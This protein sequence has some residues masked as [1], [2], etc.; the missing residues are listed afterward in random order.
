MDNTLHRYSARG[1]SSGKEEVHEA[2]KDLDKGLYPS[3]FCKI[4]PDIISGDSEYCS[5]IHADTAGTKPSLAYLYWKETGDLSVWQGIAQDALVMNFDDMACVGMVTDFILS[6]TIGRN[7]HCITGDVI[8]HL[9]NGTMDFVNEMARHNIKINHGGGETADVGDIVRT[10]DVGFTIFGRMKRSDLVVNQIRP[11]QL[12]VGVAGYGQSTYESTYNS[13][14]GSNGLTSARHDVLSKHYA[15]HYPES[16]DPK[17]PD[18][19]AY[20][21]SKKLTDNVI[22]N[23]TEY[24]VGQLLLSPTRTFLPLIKAALEQEQSAIKGIIHNT[25]GAHTK[26]TKFCDEPVHIIKDN[27]LRVPP[28][29]QMIKEE[30]NA[31]DSEMYKVFNMGTRLEL[32]VDNETSANN[33]IDICQSFAIDAQII[34]RVESSDSTSVSLNTQSNSQIVYT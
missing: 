10:V 31:E 32:Y 30:S 28:V 34:G 26:V 14:I 33:L 24:E 3:A 7:K 1:V 18:D 9:I 23:G 13:G 20:C 4:L 21:G 17:V 11:G 12:I 25:G 27:L 5:I 22:Y 29:F 15:E 8:S 6:S 2:I 16:F 19:L